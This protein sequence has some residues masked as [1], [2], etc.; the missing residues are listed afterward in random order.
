MKT[1]S[2]RLPGKDGILP[3]S[4]ALGAQSLEVHVEELVLCGFDPGDRHSIGEAVERELTR[5]FTEQG[6]GPSLGRSGEVARLDGGTFQVSPGS[7]P[8]ILG[9]RIARAVYRGLSR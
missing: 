6:V 5:L 3:Q 2:P 1:K 8:D 9:A 4:S 7:K